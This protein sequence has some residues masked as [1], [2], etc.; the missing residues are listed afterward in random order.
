M[1]MR[2]QA[3]FEYA[4]KEISK[5][6]DTKY[7]LYLDDFKIPNGVSQHAGTVGTGLNIESKR[8]EK[9]I[10]KAV[11]DRN[12]QLHDPATGGDDNLEL[13][14]QSLTGEQVFANLK[15]DDRALTKNFDALVTQWNGMNIKQ[16]LAWQAA[17]NAGD[18]VENFL[19]VMNNRY[20]DEAI[21]RGEF[22][23]L[24]S[25]VGDAAL[26]ILINQSLDTVAKNYAA[27]MPHMNHVHFGV[28]A[29]LNF[30]GPSLVSKRTNFFKNLNDQA[31]VINRDIEKHFGTNPVNMSRPD[32]A[33]IQD[34]IGNLP[35]KMG[36]RIDWH[37]SI[38][39]VYRGSNRDGLAG[40]QARRNQQ[41]EDLVIA[42]GQ[43]P[44][45]MTPYESRTRP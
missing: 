37:R 19:F 28:I 32:W 13:G 7:E 17:N 16:R 29:D 4:K 1:D 20:R 35:S 22:T 25:E 5:S 23:T 33:S 44:S 26:N 36:S 31:R 34:E 39:E 38:Y 45:D 3:A 8:T 18:K 42:T 21:A 15:R 14:N 10:I 40:I 24:N 11:D 9:A 30:N 6:E 43:D 27:V 12:R 41:A 2:R